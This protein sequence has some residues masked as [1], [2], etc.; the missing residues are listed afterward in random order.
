MEKIK[1][2]IEK[3]LEQ[4]SLKDYG[5]R[6]VGNGADKAVFE[7]PGSPRKVIKISREVLKQKIF[8]LLTVDDYTSDSPLNKDHEMQSNKIDEIKDNEKEIKEIFGEEHFLKTGVFKA[9]ILI[10]K[11]LLISLL[12]S[13]L[14]KFIEKLP[15]DFESEIEMLA[16]TQLVAEELKNPE[17]FLP[18]DFSVDLITDREF[19][20]QESV[21]IALERSR[22]VLD[23]SFISNFENLIEKEDYKKIILEIVSKI[24]EYTKKTGLMIDIFGRNN[25]TI[26][27][28]ENG[29]IHYHIIEALLPGFKKHWNSNISEDQTF[30]LLRHYYSYYYFIHSMADKIGIENNIKPEDLN[31][32]KKSGIPTGDW[33]K[34]D[35]V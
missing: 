7:T 21:D 33:P 17:K 15:D 12:G 26:Y 4:E 35:S 31:Y 1:P 3:I 30:E 25:I 32:F 10:T 5:Y 2:R 29:E 16:E 11:E 19:Y 22:D 8:N 34:K 23:E 24:I 14:R 28:K 9:K 18:T 13:N 6:F 27:K 20:S